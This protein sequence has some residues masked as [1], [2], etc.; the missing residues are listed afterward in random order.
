MLGTAGLGG[1]AFPAWARRRESIFNA[2]QDLRFRRPDPHRQR[3]RSAVDQ[4]KKAGYTGA[5]ILLISDGLSNCD[6]DP[7]Q[8]AEDIAAEG[9]DLTVQAAGFLIS[10]D[11]MAEFECI[12]AAT[13][14]NTYEANDADQLDDVVD[15]ATRAMLTM[16]VTGIPSSRPAVT[17]RVTV[18]VRNDSA[19]DIQD[20]R[21]SFNFADST[22]GKQAIVP[23][24]LP[25]LIRVGNLKSGTGTEHTWVVSYG[26]EAKPAPL[27]FESRD[28]APTLNP[29][30]SKE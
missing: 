14:G 25:P 1:F 15:D 2:D 30:P 10:D 16:E 20:A 19:T 3:T 22:E 26:S 27:A 28:G 5:T 7:C 21:I 29:R 12:A 24:V 18:S 17:T 6:P 13:G 9:F 23:A 4:L 8:V 11:G